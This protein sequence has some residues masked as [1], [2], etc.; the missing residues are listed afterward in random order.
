MD[1]VIGSGDCGGEP[2]T[3]GAA[4][5]AVL[6]SEYL[7]P[8]HEGQDSRDDSSGSRLLLGRGTVSD[9]IYAGAR[10]RLSVHLDN[11][12]DLDYYYDSID[13]IAWHRGGRLAVSVRSDKLP[14]V[15][16][17]DTGAQ[18]RQRVD[19]DADQD[20]GPACAVSSPSGKLRVDRRTMV[21]VR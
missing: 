13:G 14:S 17:R 20:A 1:V 6:L 4:C 8:S 3:V 18:P 12:I 15:V 11:G 7:S 10:E 16:A 19:S 5:A 21:Q 2:T 9:V